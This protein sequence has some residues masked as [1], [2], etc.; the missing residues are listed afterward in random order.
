MTASL[1]SAT[2]RDGDF[3]PEKASTI[4]ANAKCL[5]SFFGDLVDERGN[6]VEWKNIKPVVVFANKLWISGFLMSSSEE[7][8]TAETNCS[9]VVGAVFFVRLGQL[10]ADVADDL[11]NQN[12]TK[13]VLT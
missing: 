4:S 12:K 13:L 1:A 7:S 2:I 6:F 9:S 11:F 8:S 3:T 5:V 10:L